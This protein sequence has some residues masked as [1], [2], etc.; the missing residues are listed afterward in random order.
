VHVY[1]LPKPD[2]AAW[3]K[4]HDIPLHVFPW[5]SQ[6]EKAGI[7]RDTLY[8]LRP[9]TYV[10]LVDS[11]CSVETLQSYLDARG[12]RMG[13]AERLRAKAESAV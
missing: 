13:S 10:G 3:C 5:R 12:M 7:I 8:L 11:S 9:D 1:G 2:L 4:E 6:Y